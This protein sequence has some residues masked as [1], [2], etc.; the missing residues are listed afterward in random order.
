MPQNKVYISFGRHER[1][2]SDTPIEREDMLAAYLTGTEL[3]NILPPCATV[4]HSPLARAV[5]TA[6]FE[7]LGLGCTHLL[8]SEFLEESAPS[9]EIKRFLNQVL[10]NAFADEFY[11]HFVTHLPVV[12]KLGLPF[13]GA[14]EVCL[15]T[16]DDWSA[17]LAEN[18]TVQVLKKPPLNAEIW[19]QVTAE[20]SLERLSTD[21]IYARLQKNSIF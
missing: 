18:F 20:D 3:K 16:A 5:A 7:A 11:Y 17:M 12:E 1:Y 6:K 10:V 15:L 8:E 2:G 13:L 21:E 9:F 4:Y 14:G 19:H